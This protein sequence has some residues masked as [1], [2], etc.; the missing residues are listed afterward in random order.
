[1]KKIFIIIP[2]FDPAFKAG[3]PIQSVVNLLHH[4]KDG[5]C[6]Y[7]FTGSK[8]V[9]ESELTLPGYNTWIKYDANSSVY[10]Y[11]GKNPTAEIL[12]Q[13]D[14][15]NPDTIFINGLFSVSYSILPLLKIKD[16]KKIILSARGMLHPGALSQKPLK[17]WIY[18]QLLKLLRFQR[19]ISFHAT[20][21]SEKIFIQKVFGKHSRVF[22]AGNYPKALFP[23]NRPLKDRN[24]LV[25]I[26]IA[27]VSPMKNH[28]L[29]L[30]SLA[31]IND[32][33]D[34]HI[35]GG[36]KD[37][38]YWD[39][40]KSLIERLP[41]HVKVIC[42]GEQPPALVGDLLSKAHV[43]IMPSESE[44]FGHAI[45]EALQGGLPVITSANTPWNHLLEN[46]AGINV[47]IKMKDIKNALEKFLEMDSKEYELWSQAAVEYAQRNINLKELDTAY[48][49]MWDFQRI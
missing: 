16:K 26:T 31:D 42:H 49:N 44:N 2:W 36:I 46:R 29:V 38:A 48:R 6:Y 5:V 18:L 41:E 37:K 14:S 7:V 3:G 22:V 11:A 33:I 28:L 12:R 43:F 27:L 10:Y 32:S 45:I 23:V 1:M 15:I 34:Y 24:R 30:E 20:D 35:V 47:D 8:D 17:K 9:D 21:Q 25:L 40:C 4:R 39:K 19:K 13:I